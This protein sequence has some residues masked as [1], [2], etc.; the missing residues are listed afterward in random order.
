MICGKGYTVLHQGEAYA[1]GI[2]KIL[3]NFNT[4]V[5]IKNGKVEIRLRRRFPI[6]F[7][8]D[9]KVIYRDSLGNRD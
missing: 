4:E 6:T 8:F 3:G 5:I 9:G 2:K 7:T 1:T